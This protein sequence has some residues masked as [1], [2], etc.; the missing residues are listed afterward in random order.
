MSA[1]I[2]SSFPA[3]LLGGLEDTEE[4][5]HLWTDEALLRLKRPP[6]SVTADWGGK[7]SCVH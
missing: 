1:N 6:K 7:H 5:F 4:T 3:L 2:E